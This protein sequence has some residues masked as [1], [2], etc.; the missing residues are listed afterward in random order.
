MKVSASQV[1]E[2]EILTVALVNDFIWLDAATIKIKERG[3]G[4]TIEPWQ[5]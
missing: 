1:I 5:S 4:D 2:M 3:H